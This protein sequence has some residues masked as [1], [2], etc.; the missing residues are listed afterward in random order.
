MRQTEALCKQLKKRGAPRR[1]QQHRDGD[2][3][4]LEESMRA[5][6]KTK[7]SI[8]GNFKRGKIEIHYFSPSELER[9]IEVVG[10]EV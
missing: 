2:F 10:G 6:L 3:G 9:I 1:S 5:S 7:V 4:Y 8:R